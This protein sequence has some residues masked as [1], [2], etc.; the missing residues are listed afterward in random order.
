MHILVTGLCLSRNLGG[1]AMALTLI[2]ELKKRYSQELTF[3]FAVSAMDYE[4]ERYWAQ[5][6]N[7]NTCKYAHLSTYFS[8]KFFIRYLA[9]SF[10]IRSFTYIKNAYKFWEETFSDFKTSLKQADLIIDMSGISYVGDGTRD[11]YEGI[12]SY[13]NFYF[14][15][16]YKKPFIRFIQSFGPI[17]R[18]DVK[19]LAKHEFKNLDFIPAR[20]KQSAKE[21][22]NIT[23]S[24]KV[25]DFPDI[26]ILLES[27]P[28]AWKTTYLKKLNI[29]SKYV[30]L[31]P[32]SVA[33][34]LNEERV[35]TS[36]ENYIELFINIAN[37]I[38]KEGYT[39]IFLP[40]MYSDNI[41]DCDKEIAK[42][43]IQ[44]LDKKQYLLIEEELTPMQAKSIIAGSEYS[45]VSR[46]HA[47]VAALSSTT[48][49]VSIGWNIK[50]DDLCEYYKLKHHSLSLQF[51]DKTELFEAYKKITKGF[52]KNTLSDYKQ[53]HQES[54][55]KLD[56]AF[57]I[58]TS[59][60]DKY[61]N[62]HPA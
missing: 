27:E 3:T 20:G 19:F 16:R 10:K 30:V 36:K 6:Y 2:Q 47:L 24:S 52:C 15:R 25:F 40:H 35:K 45:V 44:S 60:L 29:I 39:L 21:C 13:T 7:L 49:V 18:W 50:Y 4:Q 38:M 8:H 9:R 56:T 32:S 33:Y 31:S 17:D 37:D 26:A 43:V 5:K 11:Y 53:V 61:D 58:L 41:N 46:Y 54:E 48:Q 42:K 14:A 51:L 62:T 1:A 59:L 57:E 55:E 34:R 23:N 22:K 28:E 12:N